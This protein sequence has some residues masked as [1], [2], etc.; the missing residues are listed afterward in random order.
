M[1]QQNVFNHNKISKQLKK[2]K[3]MYQ[4]LETGDEYDI[5]SVVIVEEIYDKIT[6]EIME[7]MK[8]KEFIK[9]PMGGAIGFN[10]VPTKDRGKINVWISY[11][12]EKLPMGFFDVTIHECIIYDEIPDIILDKYN[13]FKRSNVIYE[14]A[15]DTDKED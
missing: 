14:R 9:Q 11:V 5:F 15:T 10:D 2:L 6:K 4:I 3:A 13:E 1:K 7:A 12:A 8:E